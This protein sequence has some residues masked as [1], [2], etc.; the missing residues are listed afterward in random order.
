MS[1]ENVVMF[2][3][4]EEVPK[5]NVVDISTDDSRYIPPNTIEEA[6]KK[7]EAV[8]QYHITTVV[9]VL[10][11]MLLNQVQLAGFDVISEENK[12]DIACVYESLRSLLCKKYE[13]Y[14][15]F[16]ELAEKAFNE[17]DD[18]A[19]LSIV[20]K[21]NLEFSGDEPEEAVVD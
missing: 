1:D 21:I 17:I 9:P 10:I 7:V 15:P 4:K 2:P 14:H 18:G 19:A 12:K 16:Q 11:E 20:D 13:L 6:K 3:A 5:D 8:R